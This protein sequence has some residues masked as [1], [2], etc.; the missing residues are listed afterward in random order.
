MAMSQCKPTILV[1]SP[2][3]NTVGSLMYSSRLFGWSTD[4][5]LSVHFSLRASSGKT[6]SGQSSLYWSQVRISLRA[7]NC[8]V[9]RLDV[10]DMSRILM[11]GFHLVFSSALLN[12]QAH[13]I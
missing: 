12:P 8:L 10:A 4:I 5:S 7:F 2:A 11:A 13:F 9:A 6:I 1:V 3:V